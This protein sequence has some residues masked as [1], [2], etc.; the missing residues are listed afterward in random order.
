MPRHVTADPARLRQV[1][2]QLVG[3]A[4]T[5]TAAGS[6]QVRIAAAA[7]RLRLSVADTGS[8]ISPDLLGRLFRPFEQADSSTT[9]KYGGS[10]LGL[11]ISRD[12]VRLM[13]GEISVDSA[14]G[15]GSAFTLCLPLPAA[16]AALPP[17][18][19]A[20]VPAGPRL[21]HLRVLAA[22]DVE[23]NRL[24]LEDLLVHEGAHVTFAEHG[25][26]ALERLEEQGASAFDVVLMDVQMPVMDGL[27]ATR[28]IRE[29]APGLPVIG[30]TAHALAEE[31]QR[32][33]AA[34]MA[35]HVT[36]PIDVD[37]LVAAVL[38]QAGGCGA[39]RLI[40]PTPIPTDEA[41]VGRISAAHPPLPLI[42][43]PALLAR[44]GGRQAF[45]EKLARTVLESQADTPAKLRQAAAEQDPAA[46][47]FLAHALK[48]MAGNLLA[49]GPRELARQTEAAA[50]AGGD[51]AVK[52]AGELANQ[53]ANQL[54]DGVD[55]LLAE[56]RTRQ[57][58]AG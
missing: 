41:D 43:W 31:K 10:G 36:K 47:A 58:K 51:A 21:A 56:L 4:F 22:E 33:L 7:G 46:I 9:R 19:Q 6:V 54:A 20:A 29:I 2:T 28:R 18:A 40:H 49:A 14:P 45:V 50:R 39:A 16:E 1:L 5:H 53:L 37:E 17:H 48:G 27:E 3:N 23:V 32:C 44:Y 24:I 12:L 52:L 38:K 25:R 55:E 57:G 35:D 42:D 8:G 15:Q 11:A 13:G 30:L 26:Q 34:G